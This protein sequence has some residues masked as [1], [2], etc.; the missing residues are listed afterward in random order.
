MYSL[1]RTFHDALAFH[2][3]LLVVFRGVQT[4]V[5]SIIVAWLDIRCV[6]ADFVIDQEAVVSAANSGSHVGLHDFV[7]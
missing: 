2:A 7:S 1:K 4:A 3:K 6:V 5:S